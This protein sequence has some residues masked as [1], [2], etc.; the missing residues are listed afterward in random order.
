MGR[1]WVAVLLVAVGFGLFAFIL[2]LV[3]PAA[4][5]VQVQA[6]GP[7]GFLAMVGNDLV[8]TLLWIASW[9]VLLYAFGVRLRPQELA[10]I[11]VAGYAVSYI[12]P[13][14]NVGGEPVQAWLISRKTGRPMTTVFAALFVNRLLAGLCLVGFAVLGG[15]FTLSGPQL[16]TSAKVQVGIGLTVVTVAVGLGV[17]SFARNLH[18][19]SRIVR[20]LRRLRRS[21]R[22][23][24]AWAAKLQEMEDQM[25]TAFNRYLPY[26][27]LAFVLELMSFFCIYLRPQLF[28]YFTQGRLF[29]LSDL[30]VYFNLNAI[31]TTLI[32]LTPAGM[33]IAEGGRVGILG[34]VGI[35]P[36]AGMAFSLTVRFVELLLVG[37]GLVYLSREGLLR[38]AGKRSASAG[39]RGR[40]RALLR[41]VRGAL[42]V[43]TLYVYGGLLRRWLPRIF[44]RRYS[45]P[46]PWDYETRPYERTKYDLKVEILPRRPDPAAPPYARILELGCA[47]GLF[48][49]QLAQAGV[50]GEVVGVDFVPAAI[51]RARERGHALPNVE[52]LLMDVTQEL[53]RG[54]F[55][56]VY[57]SEILSYLGP[58]RRVKKLADRLCE[59]L[60][61]G[62]H[63]VLVSAWPAGRIIHRPFLRHRDLTV[64]RE[65]VEKDHSRPY[66]ITCLEQGGRSAGAGNRTSRR[67]R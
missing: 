31:L 49:C 60:A 53:P 19:L 15:A 18:W 22:W 27:A 56:L 37:L 39:L 48:T 21:W 3:G 17:L 2:T 41:T 10:G 25:Y 24:E 29:S 4:V 63:V 8:A 9:G 45:C 30:A 5:W 23:P 66:I 40:A 20:S 55:D 46:D 57:C 32:W 64:V 42:E 35:S 54:P 62:G 13:V 33:G 34:L 65:H 67:S 28:F 1:A 47:E 38:L 7:L 51:A 61:P 50:G 12:T 59:R 11:G 36:P 58:T 6:L 44:A 14:A 16:N 52:F 43:G 26:T